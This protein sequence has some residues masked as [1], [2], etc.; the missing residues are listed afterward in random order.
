MTQIIALM[1]LAALGLSGAPSHEPS[2]AEAHTAHH[3]T[4]EWDLAAGTVS[5]SAIRRVGNAKPPGTLPGI[6]LLAIM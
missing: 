4:T 1:A 6:R 5:M 3:P 2:H